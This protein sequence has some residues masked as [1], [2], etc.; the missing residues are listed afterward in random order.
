MKNKVS[1]EMLVE[2]SARKISRLSLIRKNAKKAEECTETCDML[3]AE[4]I[5]YCSIQNGSDMIIHIREK[6]RCKMV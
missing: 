2:P 5:F 4:N 1:V 3:I 6:K